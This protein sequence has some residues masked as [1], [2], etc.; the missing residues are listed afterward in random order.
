MFDAICKVV[1]CVY[2]GMT[3]ERWRRIAG[4]I[5]RRSRR[6]AGL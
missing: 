3:F 4:R 1:V 5:T 6:K 2:A